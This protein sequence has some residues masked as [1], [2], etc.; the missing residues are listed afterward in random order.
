MNATPQISVVIPVYNGELYLAEA[1]ASVLA[2][3]HRNLEVIVVDDGSSDGSGAVAAQF[4]PSVVCV[5][6]PQQGAA[7]A[8]NRGVELAK[9]QYLAFLDADDRWTSGSLA[10]RLAALE[11]DPALD[12]VLGHA[13]QFLSSDLDPEVARRTQCPTRPM[14]GYLFGAVLV[15]RAAYD[16]VGPLD[17]R[18]NVGECIDWFARAAELGLRSRVLPDVVLRRRLHQTNLSRLAQDPKASYVQVV[19]R[20]LDR[21]RA[22]HQGLVRPQTPPEDALGG[23]SENPDGLR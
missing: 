12:L 21:R 4:A 3:P 10:C 9:G 20:A 13:E 17:P 6:Q 16:R 23:R 11:A 22:A 2:Q 1:L 7:A 5:A 15:R 8:R 14:P 18:W 19:K